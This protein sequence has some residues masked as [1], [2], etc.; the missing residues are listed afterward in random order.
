MVNYLE[1]ARALAECSSPQSDNVSPLQTT[2]PDKLSKVLHLVADRQLRSSFRYQRVEDSVHQNNHYLKSNN[3]FINSTPQSLQH[4]CCCGLMH[5]VTG[6]MI[7]LSIYVALSVIT[8]VAVNSAILW[9]V[10][11]F[12]ITV[13]SIYALCSEK[14]KYLYPFLIISSVHIIVCI[15]VVLIIIAFTAASYG[16]F[17]QIVGHYAKIRLSDTFI[18]V[19]VITSVVLFLILSIMHLWQVIVVYSCMIFF[20]EKRYLER[21]QCQPMIAKSN[22]VHRLEDGQPYKYRDV[23]AANHK[24]YKSCASV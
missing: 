23:L 18:V 21:E 1:R 22:C 15:V 20:E 13:L 17:R 16:T 10:V 2:R 3:N 11:P 24:C 12:V 9:S 5:A 4:R 8:F 6:T 14:H 7:F 19:F